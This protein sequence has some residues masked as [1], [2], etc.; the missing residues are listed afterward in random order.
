MDTDC[1]RE[2]CACTWSLCVCVCV[3]AWERQT[4]RHTHREN[5]RQREGETERRRTQRD[6]AAYFQHLI[7]SYLSSELCIAHKGLITRY[8]CGFI[9]NHISW[10]TEWFHSTSHRA[11]LFSQI[12][13]EKSA[14]TQAN[15]MGWIKENNCFGAKKNEQTDQTKPE[16]KKTVRQADKE[17]KEKGK[18]GRQRKERQKKQKDDGRGKMRKEREKQTLHETG[19]E[20]KE[21]MTTKEMTQ[22][23]P[24]QTLAS[25]SACFK[26]SSKACSFSACL[27]WKRSQR[28]KR[29][30]YNTG[31]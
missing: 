11:M 27:A 7:R 31:S 6:E 16:R 29:L 26:F 24:V 3:C 19:Q 20:K 2:R 12:S 1:D 28:S 22:E 13:Q 8:C 9:N 21:K 23:N 15:R 30:M 4:D 5:M 14:T 10:A 17:K 25:S 18:T